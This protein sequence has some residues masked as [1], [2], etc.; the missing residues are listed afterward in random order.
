M[1]KKVIL[2]MILFGFCTHAIADLKCPSKNF[3]TFFNLYSEK[4]NLQKVFTESPMLYSS[5]ISVDDGYELVTELVAKDDV[6][7]FPLLQNKAQREKMGKIFT[8][9]EHVR[10]S[11]RAKAI[12]YK[13]DVNYHLNYWFVFK[14][15]CWYLMHYENRTF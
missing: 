5:V 1:L 2:T 14:K 6:K 8:E 3:N 12:L 4:E 7:E 11:T 13:K 10:G 9:I 15:N